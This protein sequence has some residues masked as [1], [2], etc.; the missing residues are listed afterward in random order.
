MV[1]GGNVEHFNAVVNVLKGMS[2]DLVSSPVPNVAT[3]DP[4]VGAVGAAAR[5]DMCV[6]VP[7]SVSDLSDVS[8]NGGVDDDSGDVTIEE[9]SIQLHEF[10]R[11]LV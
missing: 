5:D 4:Y 6:D 2:N 3:T 11:R 10:M 9:M 8:G 1:G 7:V